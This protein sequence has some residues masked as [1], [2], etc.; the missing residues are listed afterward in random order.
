MRCLCRLAIMFG[1]LIVGHCPVAL[2]QGNT[3]CAGSTFVQLLYD[4]WFHAFGGGHL[5]YAPIGSV[6]GVH[7]LFEA[8]VACAAS[9]WPFTDEQGSSRLTWED[10]VE[11]PTVVGAVVPLYRIPG[12]GTQPLNFTCETLDGIFRGRIKHWDDPSILRDNELALANKDVGKTITVVHRSDPSGTTRL[13][14]TFLSSCDSSITP[15]FKWPRE[16]VAGFGELGSAGVS[17]KVD[18]TPY[19]IGYAEWSHGYKLNLNIGSVAGDANVVKVA[20]N[21]PGLLRP[22]KLSCRALAGIFSGQLTKWDDPLILSENAEARDMLRDRLISAVVHRSDLSRTTSA[23]LGYLS[24]CDALIRDN[25]E[26]ISNPSSWPEALALAAN[27]REEYSSGVARKLK[28]TKYAVG[29][30]ESR[31]PVSVA[32]KFT[33]LPRFVQAH[34]GSIGAAL[35]KASLHEGLAALANELIPPE[36]PEAYPISGFTWLL[37][38]AGKPDWPAGKLPFQFLCYVLGKDGQSVPP[39]LNF[40]PLPDEIA[41]QALDKIRQTPAYS[42]EPS[43]PNQ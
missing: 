28:D 16:F 18:E 30:V 17:K 41:K 40:V 24:S 39:S 13:L 3:S 31:E 23:L 9:D 37:L 15:D 32:L 4:R 42:A 12:V 20:Y 26:V 8:S 6:D 25:N 38:P 11:V 33:P 43:C 5:S 10:V 7:K 21:I 1:L 19:S 22:L 35:P 27:F 29:Y 2:A 14:L 34:L 36:D